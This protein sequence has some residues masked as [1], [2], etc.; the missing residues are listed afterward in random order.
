VRSIA[1]SSLSLGSTVLTAFD[2]LRASQ[3]HL[4]PDD[5][6]VAARC[7]PLTYRRAISQPC[8]S[9]DDVGRRS[10]LM[11][12]LAMSS[13]CSTPGAE[14]CQQRHLVTSDAAPPS[15]T[16]SSSSSS[17]LSSSQFPLHLDALHSPTSSV[18]SPPV[19]TDCCLLHRDCSFDKDCR[20][21]PGVVTFQ[22]VPPPRAA[23][24]LRQPS[25]VSLSSSHKGRVV[26]EIIDSER[27][28]VR[29]LRHIVDVSSAACR[30]CSVVVL[31]D[32]KYVRISLN[33]S[34]YAY[35]VA[36]YAYIGI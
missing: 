4:P 17:S 22:T 30:V 24:C 28:Y 1:G 8:S 26:A 12:S 27:K 21:S 2:Q 36:Y 11:L 25:V 10:S 5:L 32:V 20:P 31:I 18:S 15:P 3:H 9:S 33:T 34:T 16:V 7:C 6:H 29:D 35:D 19:D 23:K 13:Q 14:D